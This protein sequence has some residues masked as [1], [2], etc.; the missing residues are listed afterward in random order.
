MGAILDRFARTGAGALR[1]VFAPW[2]ERRCNRCLVAASKSAL[3]A[4]LCEA[5]RNGEAAAPGEAEN[6]GGEDR[7]RE[8]IFE[9]VD[10]RPRQSRSY[11]VMVLNSG[12][13]DSLYMVVRL[14]RSF[15]RLRLL[16]VSF[17][18]GFLNRLSIRNIQSVCSAGRVDSLIVRPPLEIYRALIGHG[19]RAS[20]EA[21]CYR[22]DCMDGAIFRDLASQLAV[23]L[24]IP[25]VVAGHTCAQTRLILG[26]DDFRLPDDYLADDRTDYF[27]IPVD[28]IFPAGGTHIWKGSGV[29]PDLIPRWIF[30]LQAWRPTQA[31][32]EA[33][34]R[35]AGFAPDRV[36]QYFTGNALQTVFLL[37]DY[38]HRRRF[39]Y[40]EEVA[41]MLRAELVDRTEW[42]RIYTLMELA[43]RFHWLTRRLAQPTLE[44][45]GLS[46]DELFPKA[47]RPAPG[48]RSR[49]DPDPRGDAPH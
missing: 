5:C 21:G 36:K 44:R 16:S 17:D 4:G 35:G 2:L 31:A 28:E 25:L 12:G 47:G 13:K 43:G 37:H 32:I 7:L 49:A 14:A 34:L 8:A 19:M 18:N 27:G 30:P 1:L 45:L 38:R 11:D 39:S 33:L 46:F 6:A 9:A 42:R 40:E 29:D 3:P 20:G 48:S 23:E 26:V 10:R 22:V 15:P 41:A 24:G